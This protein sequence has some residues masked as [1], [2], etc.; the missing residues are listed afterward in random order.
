M[1]SSLSL[2][3]FPLCVLLVVGAEI[4][5]SMKFGAVTAVGVCLFLL[6]GILFMFQTP[7]QVQLEVSSRKRIQWLSLLVCVATAAWLVYVIRTHG[8]PAFLYLIRGEIPP[9]NILQGVYRANL[10]LLAIFPPLVTATTAAVL[11]AADR[12]LLGIVSAALNVLCALSVILFAET[13][14]MLIWI[15]L[16]ILLS[17]YYFLKGLATIKKSYVLVLV[18][19]VL[20]VFVYTGN[21][22]SGVGYGE[23]HR[24]ALANGIAEA[25]S[26]LPLPADYAVLY[27]LAGTA[28][29]V[30]NDNNIPT[31]AFELP[32]KLFPGSFQLEAGRPFDRLSLQFAEQQFS[33]DAWHTY[34]LYFGMLGAM[35]F[36]SA[37]L[38]FVWILNTEMIHKLHEGASVSPAMYALL[39]WLSVRVALFPIG[40]YVVDF[41]AL[42]ELVFAIAAFKLASIS[43]CPRREEQR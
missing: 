11:L 15:V 23:G 12:T 6:W 1:T 29:G 24:F 13:R 3:F 38:C 20:A 27:F 37:L 33:I 4:F 14:F 18:V 34:S 35:I 22:R 40:D 21:V 41:A 31:L 36:V 8:Q 32:R 30:A 17:R 25:Y 19:F 28:R 39:V 26:D 42:T 16:Y 43:L 9:D 10:P 5:G 7:P 2:L